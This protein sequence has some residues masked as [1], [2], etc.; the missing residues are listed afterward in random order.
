MRSTPRQKPDG[1]SVRT[2]TDCGNGDEL[3]TRR[4]R[5][6]YDQLK[7]QQLLIENFRE[8][9]TGFAMRLQPTLANGKPNPFYLPPEALSLKEWIM[10]CQ[11]FDQATRAFDATNSETRTTT[12]YYGINDIE[13]LVTIFDSNRQAGPQRSM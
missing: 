8:Y 5:L 7:A 9:V 6:A 12:T 11:H 4:T 10:V 2:D 3:D 1:P 13:D